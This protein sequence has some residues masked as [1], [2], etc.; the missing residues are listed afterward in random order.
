MRTYFFIKTTPYDKQR[1]LMTAFCESVGGEICTSD[2]YKECD[3]AVIFGSW[4]KIPKKKWKLML[5]HHFLKNDI[6]D[7]H[8][9]KLIVLETP[10]LGRTITEQHQSY[11]VGLDHFMRGL[12]DF[13]NKNSKPDR[14]KKLNLK[15]KPWRN[16]GDHVLIVGQNLHDA[17]LFSIDFQIWL[18]NTVRHLMKH[19]DRK[20]IIRDH[21]ENKDLLKEY[22]KIKFRRFKQVE[23]SNKG[24]ISDDLKNAHC[25]VSYTSGSSIDSILAGVPVITCSEYN[26]LWPISSHTLE[27]VENPKLGDREQL[28]YDLAY[29]QWTVEEIKN[30]KPWEHLIK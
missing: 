20:I 19:T 10:L 5:A 24:T 2:E 25:T 29:T 30:G 15:I 14:F 22:C 16:K 6:V 7:K 17:S 1:S 9:G 21:P 4:K 12:S 26:F 3:I 28:L 13:K 23:Y 27:D 18:Y 8:E 11:R